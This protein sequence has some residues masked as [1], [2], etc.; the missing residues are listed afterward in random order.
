VPTPSRFRIISLF[1]AILVILAGC[2]SEESAG[3]DEDIPVSEI[4]QN[5]SDRLADTQSV[6]FRMNVE[7]TTYIDESHTLR[8][9]N[10]RGTMARPD[11]VDVEFQ[12]EVASAPRVSIRMIT[13]GDESWTTDIVT[14]RW[15]EAQDEFGYNPSI[16]YDN[17][18]GLGPVM[19][20]ITDPEL[21]GIEQIDDVDTYHIRGYASQDVIDPMTMG[22][23]SGDKITVDVWID[24]E[25][26]NLMQVKVAEPTDEGIEDPATWTMNLGDH[27][28]QVTIERPE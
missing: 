27:D 6:A 3:L 13:V 8:L 12:I 17:Q 4:L 20:K 26:W 21:I 18:D 11:K 28:E 5:S 10:A 9:L 19:G 1:L 14:G 23:M 7:G 2:G 22:T 24:G 15:V 25:T 16:L